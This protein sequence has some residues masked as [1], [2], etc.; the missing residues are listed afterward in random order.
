MLRNNARV[1]PK[2]SAKNLKITYNVQRANRNQKLVF[3]DEK[4]NRNQKLVF[5]D[6]NQR[7]VKR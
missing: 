3:G 4:A 7:V 1:V 2:A 6:E 5:D